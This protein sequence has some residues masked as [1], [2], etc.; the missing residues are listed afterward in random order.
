MVQRLQKYGPAADH[1]HSQGDASLPKMPG[2]VCR[3]GT[4]W[5]PLCVCPQQSAR[6]Y[7]RKPR[8]SSAANTCVC[9]HYMTH[10]KTHVYI[11][12]ANSNN[13]SWHQDMTI[14]MVMLFLELING[15]AS[16][17]QRVGFRMV[18]PGART[19]FP[20][21]SLE[22]N[23]WHLEQYRLLCFTWEHS[24]TDE[25][26]DP[27]PRNA[28]QILHGQLLRDQ[29]VLS[30]DMSNMQYIGALCTI[31][32]VIANYRSSQWYCDTTLPVNKPSMPT[33]YS[34]HPKPVYVCVHMNGECQVHK[35]LI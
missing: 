7:F 34:K 33:D 20:S 22:V 14:K 11:H 12:T 3:A 8:P 32:K 1:W 5:H 15:S 4:E 30:P 23:R 6:D 27:I 19:A 28:F 31:L 24:N 29:G 2:C 16:C 13:N 10:V 17:G 18:S 35:I 9:I 25:E 26:S 21:I